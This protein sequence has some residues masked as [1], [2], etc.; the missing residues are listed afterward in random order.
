MSAEAIDLAL[1]AASFLLSLGAVGYTFVATR[2]KDVDSR[3]EKIERRL[4]ESRNDIVA[5][6]AR[7]EEGPSRE[8]IHAFALSITEMRGELRVI[9]VEMKGQSELMER[10]ESVVG[11]H[12]DHLM[13]RR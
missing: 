9:A 3:I 11:R 4:G 10:L 7:V 12:E 6:R 2:R 8:D 13:T 5:L 1:R